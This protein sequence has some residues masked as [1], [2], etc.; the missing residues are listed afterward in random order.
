MQIFLE[1][2]LLSVVCEVWTVITVKSLNIWTRDYL[3]S[4]E[5]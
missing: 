5:S 4:L 1:Q 3:F 2:L